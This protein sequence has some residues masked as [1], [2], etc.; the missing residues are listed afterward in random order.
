[1][2]LTTP[3]SSEQPPKERF[4]RGRQKPAR[5]ARR[6]GRWFVRILAPLVLI[7][8]V[9]GGLI[10]TVTAASSA[11]GLMVNSV[12]VEGNEQLSD[13]E[14]LELLELSHGANILALDLE[15]VRGKLLRSAWVRDVSIER[16]L[17]GTLTLSIQER[18]PV[19][20]AVLD[21]LY[22]MAPDGTM[23]DQLSPRY[24]VD[25]LL[26]VRGLS[27]EPGTMPE[28]AALAGGLAAQLTRDE[29]L[30]GL[31]SEIDVRAGGDD[32]ALHLREPA[33]TILVNQRTMVSRLNEIVPVLS[34]VR[35]HARF[36]HYDIVDLRFDGRVY[37]RMSDTSETTRGGMSSSA[38]IAS[39]GASF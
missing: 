12:L 7:P 2:E 39:G 28:R 35:Q 13:G 11:R 24:D 27:T 1:M 18:R 33:L 9:V 26:L 15:E 6:I 30:A 20:V 23:L 8:V 32:V 38:A 34:G 36:E 10:W 22:L 14:I 21:E 29:A 16:M 19:A 31:I 37:L 4:L 3:N 5:P 17:P 25:A